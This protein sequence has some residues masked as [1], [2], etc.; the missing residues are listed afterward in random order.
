MKK[1]VKS[2]IGIAILLVG[3]I[4]LGADR[5]FVSADSAGYGQSMTVV[6]IIALVFFLIGAIWFFK[7]VFD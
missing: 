7:S 6:T 4:L 1:S 5:I 3:I 2:T